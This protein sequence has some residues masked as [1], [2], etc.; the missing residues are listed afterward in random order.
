MEKGALLDF[1]AKLIAKRLGMKKSQIR[2]STPVPNLCG[3]PRGECAYYLARKLNLPFDALDDF[4]VPRTI[5]DVYKM[6]LARKCPPADS[7]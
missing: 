6:I 2:Q 5:E 7:R 1:S 4:P 3:G